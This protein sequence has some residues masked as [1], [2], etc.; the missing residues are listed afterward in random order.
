LSNPKAYWQSGNKD[1]I[2]IPENKAAVTC[3]SSDQNKID[4]MQFERSR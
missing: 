2:M 1:L 4:K 3:F